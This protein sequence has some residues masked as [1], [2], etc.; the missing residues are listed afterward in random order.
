MNP[1]F[2]D[3]SPPTTPGP[4]RVGDRV[5]FAW[6]VGRKEGV[7]VEDRGNLGGG[8]MR[9]YGVRFVTRDPDEE[10]YTEARA[11]ELQL[12]EAAPKNGKKRKS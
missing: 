12:V 5:S 11:D 6:G 2:V 4:F 1:R 10:H 7:I 9:L 8:G 3:P